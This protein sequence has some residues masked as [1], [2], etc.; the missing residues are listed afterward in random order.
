LE[1]VEAKGMH[2]GNVMGTAY[3]ECAPKHGVF[4]QAA[5]LSKGD[6]PSTPAPPASSPASSASAA[7][8]TPPK[9]APLAAPE[10]EEVTTLPSEEKTADGSISLG[11]QVSWAGKKGN[12]RY[13]GKVKF[14]SGEWVGLELKEAKGMHDGHVMGT[15]YF[16]CAPKHGAFVQ[17]NQL[18][19]TDVPAPELQLTDVPAPEPQLT[20]VP[21]PELQPTDVPAPAP[22]VEEFATLPSEEKTSDGSISLGQTVTWNGKRGTVRYIGDVKFAS[23]EWVGLELTEATGMHNGTVMHVPYFACEAKHGVFTQAAQLVNGGACPAAAATAPAPADGPTSTRPSEDKSADGRLWLGRQVSWKGNPGTVRY[24]GKV[25]FGEGEWVGVELAEPRGMHN[26]NIMGV[27]YF[28]CPPQ[29]GVFLLPGQ[30]SADHDPRVKG[31]TRGHVEAAAMKTVDGR[32]WL[33]DEI[34]WIGKRGSL[35]YIGKVEFA[36]GEWVGVELMDAKGMH[37]GNVNGVQYFTCPPEKGIFLLPG[38]VYAVADKVLSGQSSRPLEG[39]GRKR[40]FVGCPIQ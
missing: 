13:I 4:T 27:Q 40:R 7:A 14:A 31:R 29:T 37:D 28:K 9:P 39:A 3:F 8:P 26:G 36:E 24:I 32:L 19:L 5:Q 18:Q 30:V 34:T 25:E 10:D 6:A 11:Q 23:G 1:L 35:R 38:Q 20:E 2:D 33:G 15:S 12:V 16:A 22:E 21:A 17:P